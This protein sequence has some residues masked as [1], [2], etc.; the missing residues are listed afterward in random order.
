MSPMWLA[1]APWALGPSPSAHRVAPSTQV[2]LG[3]TVGFGEQVEP[4]GSVG[5][6]FAPTRWAWFE[7]AGQAGA[8]VPLC[9]DC[10]TR[11]LSL[12]TR[13]RV[14][15]T[16]A[17]G[18]AVWGVGTTT[19]RL[20]EGMAGFAAEGG[21]KTL[22]VDASAPVA[23]SWFLVTTLRAAPEVGLAARWSDQHQTR[24]SVIGVEPA[25]GVEHRAQLGERVTV[26]GTVRVGEEGPRLGASLRV[27]FGR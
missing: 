11:N 18:F 10:R 8:S 23:S 4:G 14:I 17:F 21:S 26:A 16:D 27:G 24:V 19:G 3:G 6:A 9:P 22:R 15:D 2:E 5:V 7:A 25:V 13:L 1:V 20:V 12:R